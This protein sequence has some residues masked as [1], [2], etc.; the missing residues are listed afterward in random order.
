VNPH[1][2]PSQVA[3]PCA[4]VGQAVHDVPQVFGLALAWQMPEQSCVPDAQTPAHD[5]LL[6]IHAPAHSFIPVGQV[7]LHIVP[8]QVAEPPVGTEHGTHD[9]PQLARSSFFTQTPT[10][11]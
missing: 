7:P 6:A 10:Q 11:L 9:V 1:A 8:S 4:G 3:V 5:A 2:V